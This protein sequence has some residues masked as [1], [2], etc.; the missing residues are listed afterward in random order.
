MTH[1]EM[2]KTLRSLILYT[3]T[4]THTH[5]H[6]IVAKKFLRYAQNDHRCFSGALTILT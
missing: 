5:T 6:L 2:P 4:H 3:H 1:S